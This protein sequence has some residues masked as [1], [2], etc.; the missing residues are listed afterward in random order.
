MY[1]T[2]CYE[3]KIYIIS[4]QLRIFAFGLSTLEARN[5]GHFVQRFQIIKDQRIIFLTAMIFVRQ[6]F[7]VGN[8][9]GNLLV[10]S[11]RFQ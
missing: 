1:I 8:D 3:E 4:C 7:Y 9:P 10:Q 2:N 5:I 11:I 6:P